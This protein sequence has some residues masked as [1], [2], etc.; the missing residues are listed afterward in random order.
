MHVRGS[1][2]IRMTDFGVR[3]PRRFGG[4][5]RVRDQITVHFDVVPDPDGTI[6]GIRC[7]LA[8]PAAERPN[9]GVSHVPHE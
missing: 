7:S 5:L 4:L 6:N 1:Y 9:H 8:A 3:P 2:V